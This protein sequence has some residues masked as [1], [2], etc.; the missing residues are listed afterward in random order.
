VLAVTY[1]FLPARQC[2]TTPSTPW[3]SLKG[4]GKHGMVTDCAAM[5][6]HIAFAIFTSGR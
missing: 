2:S 3:A 1:P 4:R 5:R 6:I